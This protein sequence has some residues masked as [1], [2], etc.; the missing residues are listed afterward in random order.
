MSASK[1]S[2]RGKGPFWCLLAALLLGVTP[3]GL[4]AED[5]D[6]CGPSS[7]V[8]AAL[9]ALPPYA[10]PDQTERQYREQKLEKIQALIRQYPGDLFVNRAYIEF[11]SESPDR[12]KV[13]EHYKELSEKNPN[14]S[15]SLYLYGTSLVGRNSPDAIRVFERSIEK[16]PKFAWPHLSLMDIYSSRNFSNKQ[17]AIKHAKAFLDLCPSSLEGYEH[18]T[19]LDDHALLAASTQKLR[20]LLA[21]RSDP[22]AVGAFRTLW[23]LEFK[24]HPPSEYEPLR[25]QVGEDLTRLRSLNMLDKRQWYEA[26]EDGY[27]LVNDQKEADWAKEERE[28]R[29]PRPWELI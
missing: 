7:P 8:K 22:D 19:N 16:D 18:L 21:G 1:Y 5:I 4:L 2:A 28:Q 15:G 9:E 13:S 10:A 20:A 11:L 14:D 6:A 23:S 25:K 24:A 29:F 12:E 27:K 3:N 26:L 17:E